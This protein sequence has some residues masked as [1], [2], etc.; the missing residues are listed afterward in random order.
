M[1]ISRKHLLQGAAIRLAGDLRQEGLKYGLTKQ[2][3]FVAAMLALGKALQSQIGD[4]SNA[5]LAYYQD[6]YAS[7]PEIRAHQVFAAEKSRIDGQGAC[8]AACAGHPREFG[9]PAIDLVFSAL[10]KIGGAT[11][12][13]LIYMVAVVIALTTLPDEDAE[14]ERAAVF[15][16]A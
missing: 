12:Q 2:G 14:D 10:P 15:K 7:L 11:E 13:E 16:V 1:N 5:L 8:L 4:G 9:P 6:A 3:Y